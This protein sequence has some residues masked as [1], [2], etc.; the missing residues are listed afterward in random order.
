MNDIDYLIARADAYA[1]E[2]A[3]E[4]AWDRKC[5]AEMAAAWQRLAAARGW[6]KHGK[7]GRWVR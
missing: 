2:D 6:R 4:A 7:R 1:P 3:I 5:A